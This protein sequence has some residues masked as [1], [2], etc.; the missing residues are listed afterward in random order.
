MPF[1]PILR[2]LDN[3]CR[4][5][6]KWT[7]VPHVQASWDLRSCPPH[8]APNVP[9]PRSFRCGHRSLPPS[10]YPLSSKSPQS[11][12]LPLPRSP[13][14]TWPVHLLRGSQP[15]PLP[16][17]NPLPLL[18]LLPPNHTLYPFPTPDLH[19]LPPLRSP[20]APDPTTRSHKVS[21]SPDLA[22]PLERWWELKGLFGAKT[23]P[24]LNSS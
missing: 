9:A 7:E 24:K 8:P 18:L 17:Q 15:S 4:C 16:I 13:L 23:F 22:C 1:Y 6:D 12:P 10:T 3:L 11:F 5:Q 20:R 19:T 2:D 14:R 21:S